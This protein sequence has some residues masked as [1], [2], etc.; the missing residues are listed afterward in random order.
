[1]TSPGAV[2]Y[3]GRMY[4][5][6]LE[7]ARQRIASL[8]QELAARDAELA[9]LRRQTPEQPSAE[10]APLR[11]QSWARRGRLLVATAMMAG[12]VMPAVMSD[13]EQP[14]EAIPPHT[15]ARMTAAALP[16]TG[17][18][19]AMPA[20][21]SGP[22]KAQ[23][24]LYPR[25]Q[26]A[27]F[28]LDPG[29]EPLA[30][31]SP[32]EIARIGAPDTR[33]AGD[34]VTREQRPE[35]CGPKRGYTAWAQLPPETM[36]LDFESCTA[37]DCC[38]PGGVFPSEFDGRSRYRPETQ[39]C[40]HCSAAA[41]LSAAGMRVAGALPVGGTNRARDD[42]FGGRFLKPDRGA[43]RFEMRRPVE[44]LALVARPSGLE[45]VALDQPRTAFVTLIGFDERNRIV[46]VATSSYTVT[47]PE[48]SPHVRA[49]V[50]DRE[51]FLAVE[52][53]AG[54]TLAAAELHM[55]DWN[56]AVD[57]IAVYPPVSAAA[58]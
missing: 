6:D 23:A 13:P 45:T 17:S 33:L 10:P 22:A 47:I 53:C 1:M 57:H 42:D 2:L 50:I 14:A 21:A 58:H 41:I 40:T 19:G 43:M 38:L 20:L 56:A 16:A 51:R 24:R 11:A 5:D 44:I 31:G 48:A 29:R 27:A 9:E 8:E 37:C 52:A 30:S 32:R 54:K 7:A 35:D 26:T 3:A 25:Q 18:L 28:L 49:E 46:D 39:A 4:R 36:T 12:I 55:S 15:P 34:V